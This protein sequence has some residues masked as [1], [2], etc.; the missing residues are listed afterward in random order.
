M[1]T[2]PKRSTP[3][4]YGHGA[5]SKKGALCPVDKVTLCRMHKAVFTTVTGYIVCYY[6]SLPVLVKN[7]LTWGRE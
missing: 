6:T 1:C 5:I 7:G 4:T 3:L 2:Q